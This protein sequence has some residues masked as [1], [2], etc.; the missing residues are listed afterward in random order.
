MRL[1]SDY[2][3]W[4]SGEPTCR[5]K[6]CAVVMNN[7]SWYGSPCQAY[8]YIVCIAS[9]IFLN[10]VGV[11]QFTPELMID[12]NVFSEKPSTNVTNNQLTTL[13]ENIL[14]LSKIFES[15]LN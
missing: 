10:D 8:H 11:K 12:S 6:I 1:A 7:G 3:F 5:E 14:N 9:T 4:S 13:N 2:S 15:R